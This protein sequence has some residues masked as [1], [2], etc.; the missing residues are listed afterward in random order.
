MQCAQSCFNM[1][2][3]TVYNCQRNSAFKLHQLYSSL[4]VWFIKFAAILTVFQAGKFDV[5]VLSCLVA[6]LKVY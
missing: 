2:N 4:H 6:N 1:G 3:S 5:H